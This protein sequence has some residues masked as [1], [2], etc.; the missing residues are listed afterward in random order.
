[1]LRFLPQVAIVAKTVAA[2]S[3]LFAWRSHISSLYW[4]NFSLVYFSVVFI[5]SAVI[6]S[7]SASLL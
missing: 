7:L 4:I 1:M 6:G 5:S 3:V 2:A